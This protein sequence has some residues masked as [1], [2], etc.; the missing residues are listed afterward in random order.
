MHE[1]GQPKSLVERSPWISK[2]IWLWYGLMQHNI[3]TSNDFRLQ[4]YF[5]NIIFFIR[6]P[7]RNT[8]QGESY[9]AK[10]NCR[11]RQLFFF[12]PSSTAASFFAP[13]R[14]FRRLLESAHRGASSV[15]SNWRHHLGLRYFWY[16]IWIKAAIVLGWTN[17]QRWR[18]HSVTAVIWSEA[19]FHGIGINFQ[20]LSGITTHSSNFACQFRSGCVEPFS[21]MIKDEV[22]KRIVCQWVWICNYCFVSFPNIWPRIH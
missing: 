7:H 3:S 21:A 8:Q 11:E 18:I 19:D 4:L 5:A 6:C 20:S 16:F 12:C 15:R 10:E 22:R 13:P 1:F 9:G 14:C 17:T 2:R